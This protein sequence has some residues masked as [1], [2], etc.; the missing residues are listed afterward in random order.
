L[1]RSNGDGALRLREITFNDT[2]IFGDRVFSMPRCG[3]VL[4]SGQITGNIV[5]SER[6]ELRGNRPRVR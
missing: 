5:A 2:L 1:A 3:P 6:V 4:V